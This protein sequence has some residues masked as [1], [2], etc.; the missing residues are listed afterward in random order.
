MSDHTENPIALV[1]AALVECQD[2]LGPP[3]PYCRQAWEKAPDHNGKLPLMAPLWRRHERASKKV[4]AFWFYNKIIFT[5]ETN[6][7]LWCGC[8]D[9]GGYGMCDIL[10]EVKAHRLSWRL[11]VGEIP[12]GLK[13]C[14]LCDVRA[15]VNPDHLKIGT[16]GDN[17]R[18][19]FSRGRAQRS[20][21]KGEANHHSK[22]T[23]EQVRAMRTIRSE[24]GISYK[25]LAKQFGVTAMTAYRAVHGQCWG[26]I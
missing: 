1:S 3:L 13:I 14:H 15:C 17:V 19:M 16:Q 25:R 8:L 26:H 6:C 23:E 22:L 18:E 20:G 5:S 21:V 10:G 7:W 12:D 9:N 2:P 24:T 4:P 11:F